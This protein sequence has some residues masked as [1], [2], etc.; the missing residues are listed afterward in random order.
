MPVPT[1]LT[2]RIA[3]LANVAMLAFA[4][5]SLLCRLA[6]GAGSI[7]A[8]SFASLRMVS[9]AAV[10]ALIL[11]LRGGS[12]TAGGVM[13][14]RAAARPA[15]MLFLYMA[16][17]SFAYLSLGA[18]T[19]ALILFGAVQLTM[20][21]VAL[22]GGERFSALS[23]GGLALAF[24]GL[25]YLVL[26]GLHAPD[27]LGALLMVI[28]GLGWGFY[29]LLG[30]H[31][32]DP[33]L[34]TARNFLMAVPP[35]LAVSLAS[36]LLAPGI[37]HAQTRGVLLALAS[38]ALASGC[39]YVVWY[40]LLPHLSAMR[41]ATLQ[42]SVP[43]IAALGGVLFLGEMLTQRLIFAAMATLGGVAIVLMQRHRPRG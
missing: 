23:W 33:L 24:A 15:L 35:V 42:L 31:A 36:L 10:L 2:W 12:V 38:G 14:L 34:A 21:S 6:L 8:A 27:P 40:A 43:A 7:D 20:F 11:R 9:G 37:A 22:L 5:N 13:A 32:A 25:V 17:F 28:A 39:G 41:A 18:G 30:R 1:T 26:P 19:G 4:A 3:C 16:C 29:S